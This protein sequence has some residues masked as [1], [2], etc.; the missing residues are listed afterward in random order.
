MKP[1]SLKAI[2]GLCAASSAAVVLSTGM[3]AMAQNGPPPGPRGGRAGPQPAAQHRGD[4]HA[5]HTKRLH[6]LLQITPAQDQSFNS[7]VA[8][9]RPLARPERDGQ[10]R[11]PG[12]GPGRGAGPERGPRPGEDFRNMTTPQRIDARLAM[13]DKRDAEMRTRANATKA[14]YNSLSPAQQKAMD[15][16]PPMGRMGMHGHGG[17]HGEHGGPGGGRGGRGEGGGFGPPRGFGEP[18][19][20]GGPPPQ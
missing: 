17:R 14:F 9:M 18:H 6:D 7:W 20:P 2:A 8:A 16:L 19:G 12:A 10:R 3:A 4:E 15:S 11:P 13:M 5:E 1:L